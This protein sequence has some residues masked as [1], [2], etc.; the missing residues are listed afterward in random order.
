MK[1][2]K[3]IRLFFIALVALAVILVVAPP[4]VYA[5]D[6]H[7]HNHHDDGDVDIDVGGTDIDVGGTD[8]SI[9][10]TN[11]SGGDTTVSTG[12]NKTF[13]FSHGLGDVDI[14]EGQNCLGSEQWGTVIVSRQYLELNSWCASLF[15]ELNGKHEFAAKLR[16]DIKEIRRHYAS[17]QECWTDQDLSPPEL[18]PTVLEEHYELETQHDEDLEVVQMAQASLEERIAALEK[19]P[20]PRP[21]VVQAP[22]PEPAFTQQ[23]IEAAYQALMGKDEDK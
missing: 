22:A 14:N 2:E 21:R 4:M 8:I 3:W 6:G 19:K 12:G 23:Q 17:D 16:C 11:L 15:F 20:A 9:G 7:G 1:L 10:D 5:D 18:E 13:A